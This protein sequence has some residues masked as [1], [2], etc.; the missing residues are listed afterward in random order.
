MNKSIQCILSSFNIA[1]TCSYNKVKLTRHVLHISVSSDHQHQT[2]T[3]GSLMQKFGEKVLLWD[4]QTLKSNTSGISTLERP[5]PWTWL[6]IPERVESNQL[7]G[8]SRAGRWEHYLMWWTF[9]CELSRHTMGLY[10]DILIN[11]SSYVSYMGHLNTG[12]LW[13]K[14]L[15]MHIKMQSH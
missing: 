4:V 12:M 8:C 3:S 13:W 6:V 10:V 7:R 2:A 5:E 9:C 15:F 14:S 11:I 1:H